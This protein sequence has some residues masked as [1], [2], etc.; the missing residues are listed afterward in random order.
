MT[1]KPNIR[2]PKARSVGK[3]LGTR[4]E[5][6]SPSVSLRIPSG[7]ETELID[8]FVHLQGDQAARLEICAKEQNSKQAAIPR[9]AMPSGAAAPGG[10]LPRKIG[11]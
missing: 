11:S 7:K 5:K 3:S 4:V 9:P 8:T 10:A 2:H 1:K 6:S